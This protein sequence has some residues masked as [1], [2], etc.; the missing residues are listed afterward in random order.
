MG[1]HDYITK[2]FSPKELLARIRAL[3]RSV[4]GGSKREQ[5]R[6]GDLVL[7][8]DSHRITMGPSVLS[9][10]P[11][12]FKLLQFFMEHPERAFS[13]AQ[14]LE[15]IWEA[16]VFVQERTIDVHIRRLRKVLEDVNPSYS[17]LIQTVHGTG[18][19]FSPRDLG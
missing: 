11:K 18:Y 12:E 16:N 1:A 9:V 10:G 6:V 4:E 5:L 2:P 14:L 13:R 3:F 8:V 17:D 19:R 7:E 15:R